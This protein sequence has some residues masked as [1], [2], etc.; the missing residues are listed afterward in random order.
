MRVERGRMDERGANRDTGKPLACGL[1]IGKAGLR[2][3]HGAKLEHFAPK[4][5]PL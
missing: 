1:D 5:P 4:R 3:N 2:L